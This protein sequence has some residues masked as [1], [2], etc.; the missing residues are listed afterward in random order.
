MVVETSAVAFDAD[1]V[2]AL[3]GVST[4]ASVSVVA[5][6]TNRVHVGVC[7][8]RTDRLHTHHNDLWLHSI[9]HLRRSNCHTHR[10][11]HVLLLRIGLSNT[12]CLLLLRIWLCILRLH[13]LLRVAHR[14]LRVS[15]GL[16]GISHRLLWVVNRLL[17]IS[18]LLLRVSHRLLHLNLNLGLLHHLNNKY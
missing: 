8:A 18:H 10:L 15:H 4:D 17:L 16:L 7:S 6:E 2:M 11:L 14:L 1:A 5:A 12:I 9:S 3:K 13:G